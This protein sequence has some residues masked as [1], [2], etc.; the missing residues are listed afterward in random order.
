MLSS[1]I[2]SVRIALELYGM[3]VLS[4]TPLDMMGMYCENQTFLAG[5]DLD[6]A[7]TKITTVLTPHNRCDEPD[8]DN[9]SRHNVQLRPPLLLMLACLAFR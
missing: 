9:E 3:P 1:K 8:Y 6:G 2:L 7:R 4:K 5:R